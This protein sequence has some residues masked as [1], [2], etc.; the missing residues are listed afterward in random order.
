MQGLATSTHAFLSVS[1][2]L[3]LKNGQGK[4]AKSTTR[5]EFEHNMYIISTLAHSKH[6]DPDQ[7]PRFCYD[8]NHI[9]KAARPA[10]MDFHHKQ[11]L[12]I[13]VHSPDFNKPIEHVFHTIKEELAKKI[14]NHLGTV[15]AKLLQ[16]WVVEI[17]NSIPTSSIAKDVASLK[18]T[19]LAVSTDL[20][21]QVE[22]DGGGKVIGTGGD[23]P[24]AADC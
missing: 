10:K 23:M 3:Q 17:F 6:P 14:Y 2:C 13:P 24:S 8:N 19:Y 4:L 16:K 5:Q 12:E 21:R 22:V 11:K 20:G 1:A 9:Q 18:R 7:R 15:D